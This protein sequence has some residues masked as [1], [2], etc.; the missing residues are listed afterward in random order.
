MAI[1]SHSATS[2][3]APHVNPHSPPRPAISPAEAATIVPLDQ[4]WTKLPQARRQELL[5]QL[6]RILAQRLASLGGKEVADE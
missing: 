5:G 3:E 6:T 1:P 4:L 2:K